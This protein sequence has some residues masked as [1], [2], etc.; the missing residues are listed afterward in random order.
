MRCEGLALENVACNYLKLFRL[1]KYTAY[2][3]TG[4]ARPLWDFKNLSCLRKVRYSTAKRTKNYPESGLH[5]LK[6]ELSWKQLCDTSAPEF[7][8]KF[9]A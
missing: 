3:V 6:H 9:L 7:R 4:L 2:L 5:V 1:V 8:L